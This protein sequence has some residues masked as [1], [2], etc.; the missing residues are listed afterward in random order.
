V[1][2]QLHGEGGAFGVEPPWVENERQAQEL[3]KL[4]AAG[5]TGDE[6]LAAVV[7]HFPDLTPAELSAAIQ[8]ATAAAEKQATRRHCC[9]IR[10][11]I[12]ATWTWGPSDPMCARGA[13]EI[14]QTN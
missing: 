12:R 13:Q 6:I 8:E 10:Q 1:P 7:R 9:A 5:T 14:C 3:T 2:W 4:I 11:S